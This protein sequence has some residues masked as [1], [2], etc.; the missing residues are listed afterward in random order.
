MNNAFPDDFLWGVAASAFQI[1]GAADEDGRGRSVWDDYSHTPGRIVNGDTAD[2][3]CDHYHRYPEDIALMRRLG[4]GAYRLSIS[5]PRILPEGAGKVNPRGLAFYDRLIDLLL[6]EGIQPWICLHHW[7]M[8]VEVE[9][10]GGWRARESAAV[11]G[12]YAAVVARHFGDRVKHYAPINEPN[13]IPWVAYN[14]GR[15]APG[16]QSREDCLR[17]IHHLNLAHGLSVSALRAAVSGAWIGNIVSLGPVE[18]QHDDDAHR[19]AQRLGECLWRRVMVDPLWLGEYPQPLADELAPLVQPGDMAII[20]QKLDYFG[21]NHY[22]RVYVGP[23]RHASWG[24]AETPPPPALGLPLTDVNWAV[25]PAAFLEQIRDTAARYGN[26]P[27]YITENGAAFP[28]A[29]RADRQVADTAR[30]D[31]FRRYLTALQQAI[32]E[33]CDVRGYFAWSLLDNFEWGRGYSKRFG[34]VYM[35]Y[36][37]LQ[38]IPKQS[39]YWLQRVIAGN[40]LL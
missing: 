22:N 1:E 28:D 3:A 34:L 7:D 10:R 6:H 31:Y 35:D 16:R 33:G 38:R 36:P 9:R 24:V 15:H 29:L 39:Y 4:V 8:P 27:I 25:D 2:V 20:A 11:F 23:N 19:Q 26:P 37:T 5:W 21:L 30:I 14:L 12:D 17:A 18:A 40:A 32:A 13:V